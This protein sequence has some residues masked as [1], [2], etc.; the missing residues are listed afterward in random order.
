[1]R[2]AIVQARWA[3]VLI[4]SLADAG[5]R[6]L[7][8]CSGSR[9][10]PLVLAAT[11]L[12]RLQLHDV[13]DE[14]AAAFFALGIVRV[15]G[16]PAALVCTSGTAL[17]HFLPA[18]LEAAHSYL[19]LVI[20]SADRPR[21][22]QARG[23]NQTIDQLGLL[24]SAAR[25][26]VDTGEAAEDE[27][28][29][30]GLAHT[31]QRAVAASLAPTPGPVH[32]NVPLYKPLE[33]PADYAPALGPRGPRF[34]AGEVRATEE[35][36]DEAAGAIASTERGLIVAGPAAIGNRNSR[37]AVEALID[38]SGFPAIL[39]ATSQLAYTGRA[40]PGQVLSAETVLDAAAA[41][42]ED[43]PELIVQLGAT[44]TSGAL[45]RILARGGIERIAVHPYGYFDEGN[46]STT[47]IQS[48]VPLFAE[49]VTQ[50]LARRGP[51]AFAE[52]WV[53]AG[54]RA[55]ALAKEVSEASFSE[56]AVVRAVSSHLR[57]GELFVVGNSLPVRLLEYFA[58]PVVA[59]VAV[60]SQRGVSGIDG[61]VS[62]AAGACKASGRRTTLLLGDQSLRHDFGAL[63]LCRNLP[64]RVVVV[65]NGG[66]RIFELLPVGAERFERER[67][68]HIVM[69][70]RGS[71]S[72]SVRALGFAAEC[73][74]SM[75]ALEAALTRSEGCDGPVFI[76]AQVPAHGARQA[77][78][79]LR[80][81][82]VGGR[83]WSD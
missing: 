34:V 7:V 1:M 69:E 70:E 55:H 5:V 72:E 44:P 6:H 36:L 24:S 10:T 76:E 52:R 60:L 26:T 21:G 14:R 53:R 35:A 57:E 3:D 66:G 28:S 40:V 65:N 63:V 56:A 42:G 27:A 15:T 12:G 43:L 23:S 32:L 75:E 38:V 13:L 47:V 17:A 9:S 20:V 82:F 2:D 74:S 16:R 51:S 29:L 22:L 59:D 67:T 80:A 18:A 8:V 39:E 45:E 31:V 61:L 30:R 58:P 83:R 81:R 68:R 19:P 62:G 71:L 64:L 78:S 77:L 41:T 33:P 73:V 48:E 50:R 46:H 49:A 11:R 25:L 4:A 79:A 54:R 37:R